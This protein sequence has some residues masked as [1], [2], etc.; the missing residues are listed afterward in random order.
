MIGDKDIEAARRF[1][2]QKFNITIELHERML[3]DQVTAAIEGGSNYWAQ[4]TV[5]KHLPGWSNYFTAKF[6]IIEISDE[7]RGAFSGQTYELSIEKLKK[8]LE[9]MAKH[10]PHHFA[11]VVKETGDAVTGDV[12]VQ[13]ALFGHI[14]YG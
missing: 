9:L 12:T 6:K 7:E 11:D 4:I 2:T 1:E 14:V 10:S 8:G 3:H 5:G 13:Y